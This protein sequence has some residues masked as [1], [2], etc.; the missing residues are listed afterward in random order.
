MSGEKVVQKQSLAGRMHAGRTSS[1]GKSRLAALAP[2]EN[3]KEKQVHLYYL[4]C[5]KFNIRIII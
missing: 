4:N 3:L 5:I 1:A 2:G